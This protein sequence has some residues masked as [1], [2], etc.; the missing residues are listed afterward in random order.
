VETSGRIDAICSTVAGVAEE[1]ALLVEELSADSGTQLMDRW[2]ETKAAVA[3]CM[4]PGSRTGE[5]YDSVS[6]VLY[7]MIELGRLLSTAGESVRVL[8][9]VAAEGGVVYIPWTVLRDDWK[10]IQELEERILAPEAAHTTEHTGEAEHAEGSEHAGE[11]EHAEEAEHAREEDPAS[12][13]D[14][15]HSHEIP[16]MHRIS[17]ATEETRRRIRAL[18]SYQVE[19]NGILAERAV[20]YTS[21]MVG[22]AVDTLEAHYKK[23]A[24]YSSEDDQRRQL[25]A[26]A[27]VD[28]RLRENMPLVSARLSATGARVALERGDELASM[29]AGHELDALYQYQNAWLHSLNAGDAAQRSALEIR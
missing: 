18:Y 2:L 28:E 17:G 22:R 12:E 25:R 29:G 6:Q 1:L 13:H 9:S 16:G 14:H 15:S 11:T 26:L 4:E 3:Q 23:E 27:G 8:E 20:A 24:D 7:L 19:A 21:M 10:V 5:A